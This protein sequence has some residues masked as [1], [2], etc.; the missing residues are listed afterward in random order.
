MAADVVTVKAMDDRYKSRVVWLRARSQPD[1]PATQS[2]AIRVGQASLKPKTAS[3]LASKPQ[4]ARGAGRGERRDLA[5]SHNGPRHEQD[6][7]E[8]C[9]SASPFIEGASF[10]WW[11]LWFWPDDAVGERDERREQR[12]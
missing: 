8:G 7:G 4:D 1:A 6:D 5:F 10:P 2:H 3:S 11:R 12:E 9:E